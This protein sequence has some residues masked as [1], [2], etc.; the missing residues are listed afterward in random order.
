MKVSRLGGRS[1][2]WRWRPTGIKGAN[3][4][5]LRPDLMLQAVERTCDGRAREHRIENGSEG[6]S[7]AAV[8]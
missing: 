3:D 2:H 5:E 8:Y 7:L 4:K 1:H 6:F